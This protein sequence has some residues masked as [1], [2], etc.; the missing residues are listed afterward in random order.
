MSIGGT[1]ISHLLF[2]DDYLIFSRAT[3]IEWRLVQQ[4][5]CT[6]EE[7]SGQC[8][9]KQKLSILFSSNTKPSTR[10]Q[11]QWEAKVHLC[12][13]QEKYLGLPTMVERSKY[14]SFKF[15]KD[16]IWTNVNSWKNSFL[17]QAGKEILLKIVVQ[18]S[19]TYP[20]SIF[21]LPRK[22]CK[23]ISIIM[24][25]FQ[26]GHMQNDKRIQWRK[27]SRMG[28]S[29]MKRELGFRN[30]K[31]FNIAMLAKQCQRLLTQPNSLMA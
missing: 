20:M 8:L 24:S 30:L 11:I 25:R 31:S 26:Q 23:E 7:A 21:R 27:W 9:D 22:L 12:D 28:D 2:A 4:L 19:S 1:R 3:I 10:I 14:D 29:K 17:S 15:L 13:N 6:Y 5:L 18:T 16:H